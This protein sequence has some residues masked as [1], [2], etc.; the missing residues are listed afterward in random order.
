VKAKFCLLKAGASLTFISNQ[1][2]LAIITVPVI[3]FQPNSSPS[4]QQSPNHHLP[5]V[6]HLPT[7]LITFQ[8]RASPLP[9]QIIT[10]TK[11]K[12]LAVPR[13][14]ICPIQTAGASWGN[15]YSILLKEPGD[16]GVMDSLAGYQ[17]HHHIHPRT[18]IVATGDFGKRSGVCSN[19][20]SQRFPYPCRFVCVNNDSTK[21]Y[22]QMVFSWSQ[23][24]WLLSAN[25]SA[26]S[27]S[28]R[29][30]GKELSGLSQADILPENPRIRA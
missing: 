23:K 19:K 26:S 5:T 11:Q 6:H 2:T 25:F 14:D 27:P 8:P 18:S 22:R 28:D 21:G 7:N 4:N 30:A 3:T 10:S 17:N 20:I 16:M 1:P 29:A 9:N 13:T 24:K 12:H 15:K